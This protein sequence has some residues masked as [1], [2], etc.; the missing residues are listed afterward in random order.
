MWRD[1]TANEKK[2]FNRLASHPLQSFEWGEFREKEGKKVI[3]RGFFEDNILTQTLQVTIHPLPYTP[4][5]I[6]YFPKGPLPTKDMLD[7]LTLLGRKE[8]CIF[9]QL[10]P[11]VQKG[12]QELPKYPTLV[13]SAHPLFTKYT[14]QIDLTPSEETLLK[15]FHTKTRYNIRVAQK[16]NVEITEDNSEK[17]FETYWQIMEE[18]TNRQGFYAHTKAYHAIQWEVLNKTRQKTNDLTSHLLIATY[19]GIPLV[20]WLLFVFKDML[21]YP[22]GASSRSHK[23]VMA[24]NLMMWE[25]IRFGKKMGVKTFDTWGSLG[26]NPDTHDPWYGFHR[27]KQGY[28]PTLIEFIGSYDLVVN[29]LLYTLYKQ[30][31][32]LRYSFVHKKS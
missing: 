1:I 21:Y 26:E 29:P 9:I 3:R 28:N 17:G 20:A 23:E 7:E 2:D 4:W 32:R 18:T 6:G 25:A 30:L 15:S 11:Q 16:H 8:N 19:N 10:E 13:K 24:P 5:N 31:D 22:Y 14:F 27:F 12:V